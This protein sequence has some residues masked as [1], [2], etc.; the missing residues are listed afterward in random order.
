LL[1]ILFIFFVL[2]E[3]KPPIFVQ[4]MFMIEP[5]SK[6]MLH[7]MLPDRLSMVQLLLVIK[8]G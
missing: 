8:V 7:L 5:K 1:I 6:Q 3:K 4:P 2:K